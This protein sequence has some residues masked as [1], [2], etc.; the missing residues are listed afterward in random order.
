MSTFKLRAN[1]KSK[2]NFIIKPHSNTKLTKEP[3]MLIDR[4][5]RQGI[6]TV[7]EG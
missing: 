1:L 4:L 6:I 2:F 3:A 7:G 5:P